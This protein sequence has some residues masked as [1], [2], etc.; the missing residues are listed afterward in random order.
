MTDRKEQI[1]VGFHRLTHFLSEGLWEEDLRQ[2]GGLRGFFLQELRILVVVGQSLSR[3]QIPLRAAAMT[4]ATLLAL[5]PSIV[6]TFTLIGAFGGFEGIETQLQRFIIANLVSGIQEQVS[7]FL[8]SFLAG[9]NSGAFQGISLFFLLGAIFGL[10]ATVED[11]FNQI[12]GIKR[13]RSIAHRLTTYTTIA[14]LA[15]FLVGVSLTATV[16]MQN[17]EILVRLQTWAPV[18]GLLR[19]MFS[20]LPIVVT[21]LGL[22]LFYMVMP[23]TRVSF[24][25]AF[26]SGVSAGLIWELSK[27][28]YGLY[29]SSRTMYT[30]LYGSLT[31][32]PLLFLWIQLSWVIVLGGALLTFARETAEDFR[33]EEGAVTASFRE[34]LRAALR[35]MIAICRAHY[36]GHPAPNVRELAAGLHIPVRLVRAAVSDLLAG[37]LLHEIVRRAGKGEGGLVPARDLQSLS[38]YDVVA[39][40]QS[41]GTST[42]PIQEA[43]EAREVEKILSETDTSLQR[44]AR[45]IAFI[46]IVETLEGREK[47]DFAHLASIRQ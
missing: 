10:L 20:F 27:W 24:L 41:V 42:P 14:V 25:S 17:A 31:A 39:G 33:L 9:V 5:I 1:R 4:L 21:V 16:S 2:R 13:G 6:L 29:L 32:I 26:P 38:V 36:G 11:A 19:S 35:C 30:S 34:R 12:W 15:P 43:E 23:N 40:L 3:G 37:K 44:I 22:T 18:G 28:I 46:R 47:Q 7:T 8:K 45:P